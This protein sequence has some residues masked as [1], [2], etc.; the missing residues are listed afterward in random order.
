MDYHK[1]GYRMRSKKVIKKYSDSM[2]DD[3]E[4]QAQINLDAYADASNKCYYDASVEFAVKSEADRLRGE[5]RLSNLGK[6]MTDVESKYEDAQLDLRSAQG[7]AEKAEAEKELWINEAGENELRYGRAE[8][9]LREWL[10]YEDS[11]F[12]HDK[13]YGLIK[14]TAELLSPK[15]NK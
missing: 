9:L 7:R 13:N 5:A 1:K 8:A 6:R 10:K 3:F 2:S 12:N 4:K 14:E 15:E 11:E